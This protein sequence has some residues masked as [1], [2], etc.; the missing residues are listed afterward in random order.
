M[1]EDESE[2]SERGERVEQS[3]ML[4]SSGSERKAEGSAKPGAH[5]TSMRPNK[6]YGV[7]GGNIVFYSTTPTM[8]Q[9]PS[10]LHL[11]GRLRPPPKDTSC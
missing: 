4:F 11:D 9:L 8:K 5:P 2:T 10:S 7:R 6:N 1:E 3:G